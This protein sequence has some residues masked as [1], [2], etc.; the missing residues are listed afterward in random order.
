M[1]KNYATHPSS[2]RCRS[3][4]AEYRRAQKAVCTCPPT[5][6]DMP[7]WTAELDVVCRDMGVPR[8][9][10]VCQRCQVVLRRS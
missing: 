7:P 3:C 9:K 10:P 5:P 6:P 4:N 8:P 2:C 1:K